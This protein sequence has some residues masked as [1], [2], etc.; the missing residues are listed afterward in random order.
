MQGARA[1]PGLSFPQALTE[2]IAAG[3][4]SSAPAQRTHAH[5]LGTAALQQVDGQLQDSQSAVLL[6]AAWQEVR[7]MAV[8]QP[9]L[10]GR[11][12]QGQ[13]LPETPVIR[14]LHDLS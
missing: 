7:Q 8:K 10:L 4:A 6:T 13:E 2:F 12:T 14:E 3:M 11:H 9:W 5:L 1:A